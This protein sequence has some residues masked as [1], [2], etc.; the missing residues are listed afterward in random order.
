LSDRRPQMRPRTVFA[1]FSM[2][3]SLGGALPE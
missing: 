3:D 2:S 1:S